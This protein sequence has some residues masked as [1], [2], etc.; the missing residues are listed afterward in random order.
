M[1]LS[2]LEIGITRCFCDQNS[3]RRGRLNRDSAQ[4][5]VKSSLDPLRLMY[6]GRFLEKQLPP[7]ILEEPKKKDIEGVP[8][9]LE[10]IGQ[11]YPEYN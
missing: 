10:A 3:P 6:A 8:W 9:R 5:L 1:A 4:C 2:G 11:H 7:K